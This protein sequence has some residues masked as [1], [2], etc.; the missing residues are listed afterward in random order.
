MAELVENS[1][2]GTQQRTITSRVWPG[3]IPCNG[4][5]YFQRFALVPCRIVSETWNLGEVRRLPP[6]LPTGVRMV[7]KCPRGS[8]GGPI[9]HLNGGPQ[10]L[11]R[12]GNRTKRSRWH[13]STASLSAAHSWV[14]R[15]AYKADVWK[16][17]TPTSPSMSDNKVLYAASLCAVASVA[18]LVLQWQRNGSR[19]S[20]PPGPRGYPLVGSALDVP[21][22]TPI[23][24]AF[25]TIAQKYSTCLVLA[26]VCTQLKILPL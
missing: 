15:L 6:Q 17:P 24:K 3:C 19:L 8:L 5:L 22:N 4:C 18:A 14:L 2:S 12:A 10:P 21:R 20:Y 23:W 26:G 13:L 16:R 11:C 9:D 25:I 1:V 7:T